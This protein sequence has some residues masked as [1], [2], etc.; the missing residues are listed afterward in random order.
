MWVVQLS[1]SLVRFSYYIIGSILCNYLS[2]TYH[3]D[4]TLCTMLL[5]MDTYAITNNGICM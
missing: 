2:Y 3:V 5:Y 4:E 1:S